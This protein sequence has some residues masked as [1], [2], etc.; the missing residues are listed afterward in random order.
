MNQIDLWTRVQPRKMKREGIMLR[1]LT[2]FLTVIVIVLFAQFLAS[3]LSTTNTS[4]WGI[5]GGIG[6]IALCIVF[7]RRWQISWFTIVEISVLSIGAVILSSS[8]HGWWPGKEFLIADNLFASSW[9]IPTIALFP[10]L[11]V[12]N[13]SVIER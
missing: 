9:A 2:N 7:I 10:W 4:L 3:I 1:E 11:G 13:A 8:D 12:V 5:V 6:T